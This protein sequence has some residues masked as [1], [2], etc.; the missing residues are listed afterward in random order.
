[1]Q[2]D[3]TSGH[4][5]TFA[6]AESY[7]KPPPLTGPI[8]PSMHWALVLL[9]SVCTFGLFSWIWM[10]VQARFLKKVDPAGYGLFWAMAWTLF[11][12]LL[13]GAATPPRQIGFILVFRLLAS[14]SYFAALFAMKKSMES[15]YNRVECIG[16]NLNG[17]LVY[18]FS[19]FYF[20]HHFRRICIW[21]RTGI[22][23]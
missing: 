22:L 23:A 9:F 11:S 15:Y 18:F 21:R 3:F 5:D 7:R 1:M 6:F 13:L 2:P 19:I 10:L 12:L 4:Y 20:Q 16:L 8:P 17:L 14:G